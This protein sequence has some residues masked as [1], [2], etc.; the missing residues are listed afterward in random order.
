MRLLWTYGVG[1]SLSVVLALALGVGCGSTG[2]NLLPEASVADGGDDDGGVPPLVRPD[3]DASAGDGGLAACTTFSAE[4]KQAPA[5]MLIALDRTASMSQLGKWA[6]ART[7]IVDAIDKDVFDTM[8]LGMLTFPASTSVP[9]PA[10]IFNFP[11]YCAVSANPQVPL[12]VAGTEKSSASTGVRHDIRQYLA[13]DGPEGADESDSSPIWAALD[14][15]YSFIKTIPNVDKR[16]VVL[17]TD[18]GGSCTSVATPARPAYTDNN[19]CQ[20]WEQPQGMA[21][22]IAAAQTNAATPIET[23]VVGVPGSNSHGQQAGGYDTPPYSMLLALSTYAVAGSPSTVDP[24]CDKTLTFSQA[25]ADPAHPCHVDLSNG[26]SFNAD[27]VA[28]AISAI[29]RNAL[30]CVYELPKPPAGQTIHPNEVNVVVTIDGTEH[31]VPKRQAK[32]DT[33]ASDLCWDYDADGKVALIGNACASVSN[34]AHAKV[35]IY[36][37]CAT[38]VK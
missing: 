34:A 26:A 38:I 9:G 16:V 10:C 21:Q 36:A 17:I 1:G 15:A 28:N 13:A 19:G 5:A 23:F 33:C 3:T 27:A 20:D 29:R 7:A 6:A 25:G 24:S 35:D 2:A 37:G 14:G 12:Q 30:G 18:G 32:T 22:L 4:A 11:I 8:S 31:V